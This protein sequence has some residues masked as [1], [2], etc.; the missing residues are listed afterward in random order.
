M[1]SNLISYDFSDL[2]CHLRSSDFIWYH[3]IQS[4]LISYDLTWSYLIWF[5]LIRSHLMSSDLIWPIW[6]NPILSD[7]IQSNPI[8]FDL[9]QSQLIS[10]DLISFRLIP[11]FLIS[12]HLAW[13]SVRPAAERWAASLLLVSPSNFRP[14]LKYKVSTPGCVKPEFVQLINIYLHCGY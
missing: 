14:C 13:Y 1:W 9:N 11:S 10:Y 12:F 7:L 2:I 6:S 8:S 3:L 4:H 5:Y